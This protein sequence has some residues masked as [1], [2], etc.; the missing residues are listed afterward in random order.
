MPPAQSACLPKAGLQRTQAK[1]PE[2][3]LTEIAVRQR[4]LQDTVDRLVEQLSSQM[5]EVAA[6]LR[7]WCKEPPEARQ[8][9]LQC[10]E[11]A[12]AEGLS[13]EP[14]HRKRA[15]V[16][17]FTPAVPAVAPPEVCVTAAA[18]A[19]WDPDGVTAPEGSVWH[20]I[21]S[22]QQQNQQLE[23]R[24]ACLES[25]NRC[26]EEVMD[27]L[28]QRVGSLED[29]L[30]KTAV[31][32]VQ[33]AQGQLGLDRLPHRQLR[34]IAAGHSPAQASGSRPELAGLAATSSA[35]HAISGQR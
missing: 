27:D 34:P 9:V 5:G 28:C 8:A 13:G 30:S 17:V 11:R 10:T 23:A 6:G 20:V 4:E 21:E 3:A 25:Q 31:A 16:C 29:S 7:E 33:H 12:A 35:P 2:S 1:G 22:L 24:N 32:A 18:A 19:T 26:L 15:P 14:E